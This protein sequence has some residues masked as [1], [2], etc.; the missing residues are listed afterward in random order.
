[1]RPA[2]ILTR[3]VNGLRKGSKMKRTTLI[4][5]IALLVGVAVVSASAGTDRYSF[6]AEKSTVVQTGGFAGVH[7]TYTVT[8]QFQLTVSYA[9]KTAAFDW[10]RAVISQ[11]SGQSGQPPPPR[12]SAAEQP[13]LQS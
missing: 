7:I 6:I 10:V 5:A 12:E 4:A 11:R 2:P 13:A 9:D 3:N 8:G 1:M